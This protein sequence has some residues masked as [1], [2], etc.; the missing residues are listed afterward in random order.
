[1]RE[2][3]VFPEEKTEQN[4]TKN[5]PEKLMDKRLQRIIEKYNFLNELSFPVVNG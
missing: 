1:M 2:I 4:I 5:V 3:C